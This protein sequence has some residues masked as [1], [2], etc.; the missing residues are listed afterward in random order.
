MIQENQDQEVIK[1]MLIPLWARAVE[2]TKS[3]PIIKD[4]YALKTLKDLG[5]DLDYLSP[6]KQIMSQVGCCLRGAW[7]DQELR[8][9]AT[10]T[11]KDIQV[12]QLGAGLDARYQRVKDISNLAYWYDLDL[13][14]AMTIRSSVLPKED[15]QTSLFMSL[16]DAGWMKLLAQNDCPTLIIIEGVLMYF[17]Q[18]QIIKLLEDI[19]SFLPQATFL[20]DS[21]GQKLVGQAKHHDALSTQKQQV[22]FTWA[23]QSEEDIKQ[24]HPKIQVDTYTYINKIPK[25]SQAPLIMRLMGK[26]PFLN[27]GY[28]QKLIRFRF[29]K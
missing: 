17:S 23:S 25:A 20:I 14:E 22:E 8:A 13:P 11:Q 5:Y 1:T 26:L 2:Q 19:Y 3:E 7:I 18:E 6:K 10:E 27:K 29:A 16:F 4:D 12:I 21:I 15:K 24:L 28:M 9:F